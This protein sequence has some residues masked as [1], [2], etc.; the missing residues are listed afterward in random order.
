[1]RHMKDIPLEPQR[2]SF[3]SPNYFLLGTSRFYTDQLPMYF[4]L[5]A[6]DLKSEMEAF[7]LKKSN[8]RL[9]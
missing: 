5:D 7:R 4:S 8:W 2:V 9:C 3:R 1:M 6:F